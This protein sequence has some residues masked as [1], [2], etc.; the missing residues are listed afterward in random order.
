[1]VLITGSTG[2]V[3]RALCN[4][5]HARGLSVCCAIRANGLQPRNFKSVNIGKVS[6]DNDWREALEGCKVV[7]HLAARVHVMNDD[8]H[9][10]L[11]AFRAVNVDGTLNLAQQAAKAGVRRFVFVSSIKVNGEFTTVA[12]AFKSDDVPYPED[13][14]GISKYEAEVGLHKIAAETGL[15]VVIVRPP[16]VYGPGVK[17]NFSTMM[18][19]LRWGI[20]LPLGAVTE[21]LRSLV[22]LD[23]LV[24]L[25]VT[26]ID[27]PAAANEIFLVSDGED[28]STTDLLH[29]LGVAMGK[30]ARLLPVPPSWL[31]VA[32]KL[33][34]KSD[35]AQR[36]LGNLQVDIS[37]TCQTLGWKPAISVDVGLLRAA[38]GLHR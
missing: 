8:A 1:M 29:R 18:S 5:M 11:S 20:P 31:Q 6:A 15:E 26:C 35:M 30:P 23:N 24:D 25:L 13:P 9:D 7:V 28:L 22:A 34:G 10:P 14:Y 19:W 38:Q 37:H 3:G 32:A 17:G 4:E 21:N 2:F 12:D 33:L 16:L 36:L 27:H